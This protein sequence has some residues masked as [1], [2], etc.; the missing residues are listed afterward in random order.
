MLMVSPEN[1][2]MDNTILNIIPALSKKGEG[3]GRRERER[4]LL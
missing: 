2:S 4:K 1:V 3:V